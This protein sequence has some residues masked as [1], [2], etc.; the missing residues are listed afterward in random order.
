MGLNAGGHAGNFAGNP[1]D[2]KNNKFGQG[3]P[4]MGVPMGAPMG[5]MGMGPPP[6]GGMGM[7]P[8]P[9]GAPMG[10]MGMAPPPM[11]GQMF[12]AFPPGNAPPPP[13]PGMGL[14]PVQ[15][16]MGYTAPPPM[17]NF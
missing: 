2:P 16:N 8:P 14:P 12:P 3:M 13:M 6:M 9:M 1:M 10:G 17:R 11:G 4:P 5:G 7:A 15:G